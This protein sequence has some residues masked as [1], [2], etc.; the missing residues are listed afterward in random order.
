M[1]RPYVRKRPNGRNQACYYVPI[2]NDDGTVGQH[3]VQGPIFTK[4]S[5]AMAEAI[6][7]HQKAQDGGLSEPEPE[8]DDTT[9]RTFS[10][11]FW[12]TRLDIR[13]STKMMQKTRLNRLNE[14]AGDYVL[15]RL[16]I[17]DSEEVMDSVF[18]LRHENGNAFAY[19]SRKAIWGMYLR[20]IRKAHRRGLC[21]DVVPDLKLP[22]DI[23]E[24]RRIDPL[25]KEQKKAFLAAWWQLEPHYAPLAEFLFY[26]GVRSG[27][28]RAL[29]V[30][31]FKPGKD[32]KPPRLAIT[33][34]WSRTD[35]GEAL[36]RTK[37]SQDRFFPVDGHV[38]QMLT[39]RTK[40]R[41]TGE[42]IFRTPEGG[43]ISRT[44]FP[45]I[46]KRVA[47]SVGLDITPHFSR[48]QFV[49][50]L[51]MEGRSLSVIKVFT[52][53]ATTAI[54]EKTYAHILEDSL[55]T[56]LEATA[57]WRFKDFTAPELPSSRGE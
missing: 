31:D 7:L 13:D 16:T 14:I 2:L 35:G 26:T 38:G 15:S 4:R 53:H 37:H 18:A 22:V 30:G 5:D 45:K 46:W 32:G 11:D 50:E 34:T 10:E 6:R 56:A 12:D 28:A 23:S 24:T 44:L 57:A 9:F 54:L 55:E 25:T 19:E 41:V 17:L 42:L 49:S 47:Q 39:E 3:Q 20:M 36:A 8:P 48:H 52:G 51:I 40:G 43:K 27:E 29:Q 21:R 1:P 33:R